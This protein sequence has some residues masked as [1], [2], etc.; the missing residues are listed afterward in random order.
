[1]PGLASDH[2]LSIDLAPLCSPELVAQLGPILAPAD[3][4]KFPL[5]G[6]FNPDRPRPYG[7]EADWR[8][9][10]LAAGAPMTEM[11]ALKSSYTTQQLL[12]AA[13]MTG[14]G[15]ALLTPEFFR[16]E[17][18]SGRLIQ[19]SPVRLRDVESYYLVC[20]AG[21]REAPNIKAFRDWLEQEIAIDQ[22]MR[23]PGAGP[24]AIG[25]SSSDH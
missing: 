20:L 12:A 18:D 2:L 17:L 7:V 4:V 21:R 3:L 25:T 24:Q 19:L 9:W 22:A 1:M 16:S 14:R 15:V 6:E 13:A 11:P 10:F 8:S 5:L 23:M